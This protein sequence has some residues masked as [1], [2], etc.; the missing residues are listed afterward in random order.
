M[1]SEVSSLFD[2]LN[3]AKRRDDYKE[4]VITTAKCLCSRANTFEGAA[5]FLEDLAAENDSC[6]VIIAESNYQAQWAK[7]DFEPEV[8][9]D[10]TWQ[11][12]QLEFEIIK[13]EAILHNRPIITSTQHTHYLPGDMCE[14]GW[15]NPDTESE[16]RDAMNAFR[17]SRDAAIARVFNYREIAEDFD[18]DDCDSDEA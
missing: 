12:L 5:R 8:K 10:K 7:N 14:Y 16:I 6:E 2:L 11:E 1:L 4:L 9:D 17:C 13:N 18:D 15:Y 3:K